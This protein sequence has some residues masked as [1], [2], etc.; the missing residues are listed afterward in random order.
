MNF[1]P[2][3]QQQQQTTTNPT[4]KYWYVPVKVKVLLVQRAGDLK[5]AFLVAYDAF[6]EDE[7]PLVGTHVLGSVPFLILTKRRG[8][9]ENDDN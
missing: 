9:G 5:N 8:E 2:R 3:Q 7:G 4:A 6:R 1:T